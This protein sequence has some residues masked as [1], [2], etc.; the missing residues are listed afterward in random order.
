MRFFHQLWQGFWARAP[1]QL[2]VRYQGK[3]ILGIAMAVGFAAINTGNNQLFLCWGIL[4]SAIVLSGL[5]SEASLRFIELKA[6]VPVFPRVAQEAFMQ[7]DLTNQASVIPSFAVE[8]GALTLEKGS[9]RAIKGPFNLKVPPGSSR[10]LFAR[11]VPQAR[12][13]C[14][15]Q[16][17]VASTT[18]P[19]GF[20]T[21]T[22]RFGRVNPTAFWVGP[23]RVSLREPGAAPFLDA[24]AQSAHRAGGGDDFFALRTYREGEDLRRVHWPSSARS[25]VWMVREHEA[26]A[27]R[28]VVLVAG[29]GRFY[30]EH[31]ALGE[32]LLSVVGS[33]AEDLLAQGFSVGVHAPGFFVKPALHDRQR[34]AILLEL[35]KLSFE[36]PLPPCR[37]SPGTARLVISH[38]AAPVS[39]GAGQPVS[40]EELLGPAAPVEEA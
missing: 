26:V 12:G 34:D 11:F 17:S 28:R 29:G 10:E 33:F 31:P 35:A 6:S 14:Q 16:Y 3:V 32:E 23:A 13:L 27:G 25:K 37:L 22:R 40:V 18:Y 21:K 19:F 7:F 20:F 4:L 39:P 15:I 5:L 8:V 1:R 38:R 2:K 9:E 24:G 36:S 30:A